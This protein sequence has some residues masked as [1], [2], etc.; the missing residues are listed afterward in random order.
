M[1]SINTDERV[2]S[3][4]SVMLES[5]EGSLVNITQFIDQTTEQLDG[6]IGQREEIVSKI[7]E[8]KDV[9]GLEEETEMPKLELVKE[10]S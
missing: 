3:F 7:A 6:A 9:L 2:E 5:Y 10:E 1:D 8:L 4:L